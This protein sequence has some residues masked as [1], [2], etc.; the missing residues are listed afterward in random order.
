QYVAAHVLQP[1]RMKE[2][3]YNPPRSLLPR[4]APTEIDTLRG[5]LVRGFVHDERA[6]YLGG[7]AAHAGL[8]SSGADM[9]RF[10]AMLLNGGTLDGARVLG[11]STL[12]LF[13]A[14]QDSA[15]SNRALGW[16]KPPA[17]WAGTLMSSHAFGHTGFTGTSIAIDPDLKLYIILLTNR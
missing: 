1:L 2:T 4:I 10:A 12:D 5:G 17:A 3:M 6:Y 14:Y 15:F 13:T 9:A 16:Q 7:V 11:S 8:F